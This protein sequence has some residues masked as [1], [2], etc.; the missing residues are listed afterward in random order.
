MKSIARIALTLILATSVTAVADSSKSIPLFTLKRASTKTV[1]LKVE[2]PIIVQFWATWCKTCG[3]TMA[4]LDKRNASDFKTKF[5]TVAVD[6]EES[7]IKAYLSKK[8]PTQH[9][10]MMDNTFIDKDASFAK[11]SE[12][13]SLPHVVVMD[14]DGKILMRHVGHPDEATLEKMRKLIVKS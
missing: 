7:A 6:D 10:R 5:F 2:K 4:F 3:D 14:V 8:L 11:Q 12:V 13:N 1:D 9:E